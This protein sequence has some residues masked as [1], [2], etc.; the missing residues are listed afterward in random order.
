MNLDD[1]THPLEQHEK[2][3]IK[4]RI[5]HKLSR[6]PIDWDSLN[7][8]L[9][10]LEPSTAQWTSKEDDP[11]GRLLLGRV[12]SSQAPLNV[13]ETVLTVF[14]DCLMYNPAAFFMACRHYKTNQ[15]VL[16]AMVKHS[17]SSRDPSDSECPFPWILSDL[18]TVS[19]AQAMLEIY[20]QGVLEPSPMLSGK[21]L[22]DYLVR[23]SEL[24]KHEVNSNLWTKFKLILV[25]A[26]CSQK[27]NCTACKNFGILS[28]AHVLLKRILSYPGMYRR[29]QNCR[30]DTFQ[31][32]CI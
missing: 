5:E 22:I 8:L 31:F 4:R 11:M 2:N 21:T 3:D 13:V 15:S 7:P 30:K 28:P 1:G 17:L 14:P 26:E 12:L 32:H 25:S 23:S 10:S 19:A 27:A 18:V 9:T 20:P 16:V 24:Q 6:L 29:W